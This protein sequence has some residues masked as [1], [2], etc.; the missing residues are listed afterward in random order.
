MKKL[1][2]ILTLVLGLFI[3]TGIYAQNPPKARVL[4]V[5]ISDSMAIHVYADRF[6]ASTQNKDI[7]DYGKYSINHFTEAFNK[8]GLE[9]V[10]VEAPFYFRTATLINF[11]NA[12]TQKTK[13]W[14]ADLRSKYDADFLV[15][16]RRKFVPEEKLDDRFLGNQQ[17]GLATYLFAPDVL[18]VFSFVGYYIFSLKDLKAVKMNSNHEKYVI[19][20]IPLG[21]ALSTDEL[22]N[23][24]SKYLGMAEDQLKYIADT[25]NLEV[26][27][28]VLNYLENRK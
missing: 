20:D 18:S 10:Q 8:S 28:V 24:P 23:V 12:P 16:I 4:I 13:L 22:I 2:F 6:N 7:F 14:L 26:E 17:Y 11:L 1:S 19:T 27:R 15:V 5:N 3:N 25:R 21:K 9:L